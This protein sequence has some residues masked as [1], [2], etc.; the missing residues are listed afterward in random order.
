MTQRGFL[1]FQN[2]TQY[3]LELLFDDPKQHEG[4]Y[5]PQ[6][7]YA[8]KDLQGVEHTVAQSIGSGLDNAFNAG[9]KGDQFTIEKRKNEAGNW[10][11]HVEKGNTAKE[12]VKPSSQVVYDNQNSNLPPKGQ[13]PVDWDLKEEK[14]THE[15]AKAVCIKL[16]VDSLPE[17]KTWSA[18]TKKE[19]NSRFQTLMTLINNEIDGVLGHIEN[20]TNVF[21]LNAMWKKHRKLWDSILTEEEYGIAVDASAK[22]K[23]SFEPEKEEPVQEP[24]PEIDLDSLPF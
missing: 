19:L 9:S 14:K 4:N 13:P 21:H 8:V 17:A 18:T 23:A 2:A 15:I 10:V 5:G 24:L 20:A 12:A 6:H 1:N 11:F 7:F 22:K 3:V 16:A